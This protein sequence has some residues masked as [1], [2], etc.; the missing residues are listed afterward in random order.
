MATTSPVDPVEPDP[1]CAPGGGPTTGKPT[2]TRLAPVEGAESEAS[3]RPSMASTFSFELKDQATDEPQSLPARLHDRY[4]F[5]SLLGQGGF[6]AVFEAWDEVLHRTV[7]VKVA[8]RD[9]FRDG[10]QGRER[11]LEEA[12]AAAKLKHPD[13]VAVYDS[14]VDAEGNPYVVFEFI[15]GES[16]FERM[17]RDPLAVETGVA[18]IIS[19][20]EA[21]HVAHKLGLVH[22]DLKPQNI[23]L[24]GTGHPH[25]TDFGLAVDEQSQRDMAGQVAGSPHY[26]SPEQ[27]R[28]EAQY[29]D[30]RTDVWALGVILYELLVHRRPFTGRNPQELRDEILR[31]EPRPLRT[32]DDKIPPELERICLKCTA[33]EV[34]QRYTTA[35]D[36]AHDLRRWSSSQTKTPRRMGAA[37][38]WGAVVLTVSV[39][40]SV[41]VVQRLAIA[42]ADFARKTSA[43]PNAG[44]SRPGNP[45]N[46]TIG[47]E[48]H[49]VAADPLG[50]R[51]R[52]AADPVELFWPAYRGTGVLG[53]RNELQ[54]Y[55]I[56]S[57]AVR[58]VQLGTFSEPAGKVAVSFKQPL[59]HGGA[60]LFFGYRE[61]LYE[62]HP[63]AR[64]QLFA[65]V[66]T[67][68]QDGRQVYRVQRGRVVIYPQTGGLLTEKEWGF[69][70][71]ALPGE[72]QAARL[73]V[74]FRKQA[75]VAVSW[76]SDNLT[77][78]ATPL[79]NEQSE[80]D[81]YVGPWG[82]FH[83]YG[84]TWFQHPD[85]QTPGKPAQ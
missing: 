11:F 3:V 61:G 52:L 44:E 47:G 46:G 6:G 59:W 43:L 42:P 72:G 51:A 30:G 83:Q 26:M 76:R 66:K 2:A 82:L 74:E 64:F 49:S 53:F 38:V 12:R 75:V 65:L 17:K 37:V 18:L 40:I 41:L 5:R 50:W 21:I 8:R 35:A 58:L 55:E 78:L 20:A 33:K 84:T 36:L 24:D 25:V 68:N 19:V 67:F 22:R 32:I 63:C 34:T 4:E 48:A 27:V 71:V 1:I 7:A 31:R 69:H 62:G 10:T 80:S 45:T 81:D 28:G 39:P 56:N 16:L 60:G 77:E 13:I 9:R 14:G 85:S 57:D 73:I 70:D 54:S 23:L 79:F 29:L 15:A